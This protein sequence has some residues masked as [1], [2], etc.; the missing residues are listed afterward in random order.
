MPE[1]N[2]YGQQNTASM[3][4][5]Q[6]VPNQSTTPPAQ[7]QGAPGGYGYAQPAYQA[8]QGYGYAPYPVPPQKKKKRGWI[9][10][11]IVLAL[12]AI[13]AFSCYSCTAGVEKLAGTK[14]TVSTYQ[15]NTVA[16]IDIDSTIQYN[17]TACSPE[18]LKSLLDQAENDGN[19]KAVVLRVDSGGG[20]ATAG[21]EMAGYVRDFKKPIVVSTASTNASAAYEI[22]S[23]ADYIF[24]NQTSVVGA[25]G[26][27]LTITDLSGL[28]EKLGI[29]IDNITSSDSK[30]SSYGTRA[31]TDAERAYY[32]NEVDQINAVFIKNVASGRGMSEDS[33]RALAT[34]MPFTG[35]EGVKNGLVDAIGN[36][37]DAVAKAAELAGCK[38]SYHVASLKISK[39]ELSTLLGLLS[40][41][42]S[43]SSSSTDKLIDALKELESN[44]AAAK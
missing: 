14:G 27:D 30:D 29:K 18:G 28:L 24:A 6:T 12:I 40:S 8:P 43:S 26:T 23:Q 5:Q 1:Q 2:E 42:S 4:P 15:P 35:N 25:I 37:E 34:G 10:A 36:R 20:T 19:I 17:G 21:E 9:V 31:L 3:P 7:Q 13:I 33:V 38:S 41:S 39:S 11:I 22:S 16:V 44:G 32:Q